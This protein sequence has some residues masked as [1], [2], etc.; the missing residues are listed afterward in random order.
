M[1]QWYYSESGGQRGPVSRQQI[2]E[3]LAS[4]VLE[5]ATL[6]W[7]EGMPEWQ[8]ASAVPGL[9]AVKDASPSDPA[10]DSSAPLSPYAPPAA[11]PAA[12]G[13]VDWSGYVPSGPQTR[14]WV[15]YWA[16]SFD[17]LLFSVIF[18]GAVAAFVPDVATMND[19]LFGVLLLFAYNF[20]EPAMLSI[21]GATPFK[22]LLCIR[23]RNADG[24]KLS[25]PQGLRRT[26]SLWVNG[27]GLGIPLVQFITCL[28]AYN[29]LNNDG[30]TSWDKAG[31]FTVS[32]Q[33][34][35][36][37]R[38]LLAIAALVGFVTLIAMGTELAIES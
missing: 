3:M 31:P 17:Y 1:D 20:A 38:W 2:G 15:R 9:L 29:K 26:I 16:R 30:I 22:A 33:T 11:A 5:P 32:H 28:Y 24:T 25:Y 7:T 13:D 4:G 34:I 18:G 12:A 21:F 14:P 37:W 6:V 10:P 19:T 23:V 27:Q 8:A 35:P 36:W